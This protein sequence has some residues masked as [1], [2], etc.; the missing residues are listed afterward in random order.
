MLNY[1]LKMSVVDTDES[2]TQENT[3]NAR[4]GITLNK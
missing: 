2:H 3:T 4:S 1:R